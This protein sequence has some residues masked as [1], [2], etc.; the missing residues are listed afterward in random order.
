[1]QNA[2]CRMRQLVAFCIFCKGKLP[3][4]RLLLIM[5]TVML[6]TGCGSA[7]RQ[8]AATETT[9]AETHAAP[10]EETAAVTELVTVPV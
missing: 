8:Q 9:A 6:L 3:M 1:M 5:I 4:K 10:T 7:E 2:E